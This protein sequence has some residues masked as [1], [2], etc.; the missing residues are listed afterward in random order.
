MLNA[1]QNAL[2]KIEAKKIKLNYSS[3]ID[4]HLF[5]FESPTKWADLSEE[6]DADLWLPTL[7]ATGAFEMRNGV[8]RPRTTDGRSSYPFYREKNKKI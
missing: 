1:H 5:S 2:Q 8:K 6:G 3:K 4:L 7:S